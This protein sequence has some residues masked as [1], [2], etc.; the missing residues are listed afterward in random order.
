MELVTLA[1][2]AFLLT[3]KHTICDLAIQRL[4]P[5][6][7]K[8]YFNPPAHTHYFHHGFGSFLVGLMFGVPFA[9]AIGVIDYFAHWHIDYVK[10]LIKNH[11][12]LTTDNN[13]FWVLQSIDQ[14]LHFATYYLFLL[15][16]IS[17]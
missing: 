3:I 5:A 15:I 10:T 16:A 13:A 17:L 14:A 6:D 4:F 8:F 12:E 2:F 1:T 11:F 7:K 9:V